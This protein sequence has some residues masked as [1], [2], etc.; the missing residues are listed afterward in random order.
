MRSVFKEVAINV[1]Q[2]CDAENE[3]AMIGSRCCNGV[4]TSAA[5]FYSAETA[6]IFDDEIIRGAKRS[7]RAIIAILK[8]EVLR[9]LAAATDAPSTAT[10]DPADWERIATGGKQ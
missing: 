3:R 2:R 4:A 9:E 6:K 5:R 1:L 8:S 10:S 7:Q